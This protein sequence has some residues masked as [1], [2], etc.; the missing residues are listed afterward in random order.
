MPATLPE[1][2]AHPKNGRLHPHQCPC[3]I[4]KTSLASS[5]SSLAHHRGLIRLSRPAP[6]RAL[7]AASPLRKECRERFDA[8]GSTVDLEEIDDLEL[9]E[10]LLTLLLTGLPHYLAS[11]VRKPIDLRKFANRHSQVKESH[12]VI[13]F[14]LGVRIGMFHRVNMERSL[15]A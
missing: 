4:F 3:M 2:S 5:L 8:I 7:V 14:P 11:L 13:S 15:S 12:R 9:D 10:L 1:E 6:T